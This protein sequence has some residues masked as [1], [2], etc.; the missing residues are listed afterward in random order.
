MNM[1]TTF[2]S[3]AVLGVA[4]HNYSDQSEWLQMFIEFNVIWDAINHGFNFLV[5]QMSI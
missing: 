4:K 5:L 3:V 2:Q 1:A